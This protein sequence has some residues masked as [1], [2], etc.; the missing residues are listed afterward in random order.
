[1]PD[2]TQ[3]GSQVILLTNELSRKH[4]GL[5]AGSL[6]TVVGLPQ[7]KTQRRRSEAPSSSSTVPNEHVLD[8]VRTRTLRGAAAACS[9]RGVR[10]LSGLVACVP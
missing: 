9:L 6:G 10:S 3:V 8:Q 4:K 5:N 7:P 2:L 1:M